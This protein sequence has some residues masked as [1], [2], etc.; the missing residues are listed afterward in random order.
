M[1][2]ETFGYFFKQTN[3]QTKHNTRNKQG[4]SKWD[5]PA[6]GPLHGRTHL[7]FFFVFEAQTRGSS[8]KTVSVVRPGL[9]GFKLHH[10]YHQVWNWQNV[11]KK[12][13]RAGRERRAE[14]WGEPVRK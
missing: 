3:K 4:S 14:I 12:R 2:V 10:L 9:V 6:A 11:K 8:L 1:G 7:V 5:Q 13:S